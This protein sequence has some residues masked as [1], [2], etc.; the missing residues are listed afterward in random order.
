MAS[1]S[2]SV[3]VE[4]RERRRKSLL[5]INGSRR[6]GVWGP[7]AHE[8]GL[9]SHGWAP[10]CKQRRHRTGPAFPGPNAAWRRTC[11]KALLAG[12]PS[13]SQSLQ[14]KTSSP[15]ESTGQMLRAR[16]PVARWGWRWAGLL[17]SRGVVKPPAPYSRGKRDA[18]WRLAK[19]HSGRRRP[20]GSASIF[21]QRRPLI[22]TLD[23]AKHG[24]VRRRLF[25]LFCFAP[26][27]CGACQQSVSVVLYMS[28]CPRA[29]ASRVAA[30]FW[31]IKVI[32]TKARRCIM[33]S[34]S[35]SS[36]SAAN[37]LPHEC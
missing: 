33:S 37:L 17:I 8:A 1:S 27:L 28:S 15:S 19:C 18:R 10:H 11:G 16:R 13:T 3:G 26:L 7:C 20:T 5:L 25:F 22:S 34:L 4:E 32:A 14:L 23:A 12:A 30:I 35:V 2:V 24:R 36:T 6:R 31:S 9:H 29:L 21:Y